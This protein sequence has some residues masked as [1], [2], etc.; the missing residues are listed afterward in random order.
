[1]VDDYHAA[2]VKRP[3]TEHAIQH[4]DNS[5]VHLHTMRMRACSTCVMLWNTSVQIAAITLFTTP[6]LLLLVLAYHTY[7]DLIHC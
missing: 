4:Y 3:H 1:M 2:G 6:C 7:T 5:G